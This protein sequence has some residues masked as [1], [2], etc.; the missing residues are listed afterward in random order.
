MKVRFQMKYV[1]VAL[2]AVGPS[3]AGAEEKNR[4]AVVIAGESQP[5]GVDVG[6]GE[7]VAIKPYKID[8]GAGYVNHGGASGATVTG[9]LE[10]FKMPRLKLNN[11]SIL[12]PVTK[13]TSRGTTYQAGWM[14]SPSGEVELAAGQGKEST[15]ASVD[16]P[17][18]I[19]ARAVVVLPNGGLSIEG[20]AGLGVVAERRMIG[21]TEIKQFAPTVQILNLRT[22][23]PFS[24]EHVPVFVEANAQVGSSTKAA[25]VVSAETGP[26]K[27][28]VS[29]EAEKRFDMDYSRTA[30]A[31]GATVQG[32]GVQ[33]QHERLSV[34]D[35][36]V[37]RNSVTV[38]GA[39]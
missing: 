32:V 21:E 35:E 29:V 15:V 10:Y 17:T 16:M 33:L 12:P 3:Q 36:S 39:F 9:R 28:Y 34:G 14:V 11:L 2:L 26:V 13:T 37:P 18:L 31:A 22:V 19:G 8:V 4:P 23:L 30:I 6:R 5:G 20:K 24:I 25:A 1:F 7:D 38:V 27:P